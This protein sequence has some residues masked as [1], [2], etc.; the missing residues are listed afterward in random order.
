[1]VEIAL[2][3]LAELGGYPKGGR[4][5]SILNFEFCIFNS[6]VAQSLHTLYRSP[7]GRTFH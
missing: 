6:L 7:K 1:M 4:G 5:L 2:G 3:V